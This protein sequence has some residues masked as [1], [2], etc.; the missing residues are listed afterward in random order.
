MAITDAQTVDIA[1][2]LAELLSDIDGLRIE[3][4]VSDK[5][6]PPCVVIARP[7]IDW[8][9]PEAGFCWASWDFPITIITTRSWDRSAQAEES[10]LVRDVANALSHQPVAGVHD[11]QVQTGDPGSTTIAGQELPSYL[12]RVRVLA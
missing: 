6:R 4:Y 3:P 7:R 8:E 2:V 10:R 5:S 12:L 1:A 9:D 11:I